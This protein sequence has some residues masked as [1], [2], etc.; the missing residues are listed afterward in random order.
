MI[1]QLN[2][3]PEKTITETT[4]EKLQKAT[5]GRID[6]DYISGKKHGEMAI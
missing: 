1:R 6:I 2:K 5:F 3:K 4:P